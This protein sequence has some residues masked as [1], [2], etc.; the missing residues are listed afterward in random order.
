M[1]RSRNFQYKTKVCKPSKDD[2]K[3]RLVFK[4]RKNGI[5]WKLSH[6]VYDQQEMKHKKTDN[7]TLIEHWNT[8]EM[9]TPNER[10]NLELMKK[11]WPKWRV[12]YH[13]LAIKTGKK[14]KSETEKVNVL[15]KIYQ[16]TTSPN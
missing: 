15:L 14:I 8:I 13:P 4:P 12:Y 3:E 1:E 6:K 9:L 11:I 2:F 16:Q 7:Q 5:C 10:N